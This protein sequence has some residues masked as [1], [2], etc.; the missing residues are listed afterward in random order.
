MQLSRLFC[1]LVPME[2]LVTLIREIAV[3]PSFSSYEERIHDLVLTQM[4]QFPGVECLRVPDNNLVFTVPG[5]EKRE[6]VALTAHLDKINHFGPSPPDKLPFSSDEERLT[7]QLDN[8]VGLALSMALAEAAT[9]RSFPPLMLLFSEMEESFGLNNH[10]HLLKNN[11][12]GLH[13]GIGAE[14]IS[15]FLIRENQLPA[16]VI[17]LDTTPLF[18]GKPGVALY[19]GHWEFTGQEPSEKERE[20]TAKVRD[21]FTSIDPNLLLSNNTNDYLHYGAELNRNRFEAIPSLALEPA[22]FPYHQKNESVFIQD[23]ERVYRIMTR[24]LEQV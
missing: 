21:E 13:H 15:Q 16:A 20:R 11:G 24:W 5:D 17:T 8:A 14:R 10:P 23:I 3:V 12:E 18:K 2:R 22:I 6:P 4:K 1:T 9:V 7:G 19:S